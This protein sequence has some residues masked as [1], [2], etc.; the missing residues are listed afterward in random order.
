MKTIVVGVD[1]SEQSRRALRFAAAEAELRGTDLH[2]IHAWQ[3]PTPIATFEGVIPASLNID[4]GV[5]AE[6]ATETIVKETLGDQDLEIAVRTSTV[7]GP[8][9]HA[10]VEASGDADLVV[11]GSR[12]H[13]RFTGLLLGSVSQ[14]VAQHSAC[15]VV[16]VR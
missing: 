8:A 10:L 13:G 1:G 14:Q 12:G 16:I 3:Y 6:H 5:E 4:F 11:V 7:R 15:P 9:A 2:V